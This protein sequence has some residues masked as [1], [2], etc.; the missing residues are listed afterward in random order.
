MTRND[1]TPVAVGVCHCVEPCLICE[2]QISTSGS[3]NQPFPGTALVSLLRSYRAELDGWHKLH[4]NRQRQDLVDSCSVL[5]DEA[6]GG[7]I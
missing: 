1:K 7:L 4:G 5:L 2:C 6:E 3:G